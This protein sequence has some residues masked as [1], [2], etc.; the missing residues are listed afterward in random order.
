MVAE[1]D[2]TLTKKQ[3]KAKYPGG[4]PD[5]PTHHAGCGCSGCYASW[6]EWR[7]GY[8]AVKA[9]RSRL[10]SIAHKA[11]AHRKRA[12]KD[13]AAVITY[14]FSAPEY[15]DELLSAILDEDGKLEPTAPR[16]G[17]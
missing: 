16:F 8:A 14:A 7:G 12:E 1:A 13:G 9:E 3:I 5:Y 11:I 10:R 15:L 6:V 17:T 4:S 2:F